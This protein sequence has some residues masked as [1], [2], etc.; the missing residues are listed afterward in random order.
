LF[1]FLRDCDIL[2]CLLP[3]N[4]ETR[5]ILNR[6]LFHALP[7]GA[8]IINAGRGGHLVAKDLCQA[9]DSRHLSSAIL[10]VTDPEPLPVGH[11]LWRHPRVFITAHT[12]A[13]TLPE[14]AAPVVIDNLR[15][16]GRGEPLRGE[17]DR[18]RGY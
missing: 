17:I 18:T 11:P 8:A 15:R 6:D 10:D 2:V 5:G 3:L 16:D 1:E 14:S 12:A 13:Q 9:L 7:K 4:V